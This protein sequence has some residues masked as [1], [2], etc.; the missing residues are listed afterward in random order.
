MK[1]EKDEILE[2]VKFTKIKKS[3]QKNRLDIIQSDKF[4]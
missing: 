4:T 1:T 3:W 2:K